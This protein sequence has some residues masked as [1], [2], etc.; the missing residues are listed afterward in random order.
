MKATNF[1]AALAILAGGCAQTEAPAPEGRLAARVNGTAITIAGNPGAAREASTQALDKVIDREL[2]VQ[3]ALRKGLDRD[4]K[5]AARIEDARR[6]VLAQAW[7]DQA[8]VAPAG[9]AAEPEVARFYAENPALFAQRRIYRY[10]ELVVSAPPDKLELV[11]GELAGARDLEDVAGWLKWRSLKV[12]QVASATAAAEQ[13]PLSYLPQLARMKP[14]DMAVFPSPLGAS[15]IQLVQ[16]QDAPLAESEAAPVIEQFLAGR[17]RLEV[18]AAELKRLR[19]A[20]SIEYV[21]EF[22]R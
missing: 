12:S 9:S 14:G 10:Q 8:A 7:L 11:R 2:L 20:A 19:G 16:A 17:R 3:E 4:P 1:L 21:G 22:K 18:A 5:V 13:L 15:V 6:E